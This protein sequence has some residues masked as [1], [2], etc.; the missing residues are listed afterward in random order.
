MKINSPRAWIDVVV[1][2]FAVALFV[3]VTSW[4]TASPSD[5][6]SQAVTTSGATNIKQATA[7]SFLSAFTSVLA[8][9]DD[10]QM[11]NYVAAAQKL[12]PDLKDQ[13]TA[14]ANDFDLSDETA[15]NDDHHVSRHR[16]RVKICCN[17]R[18]TLVLPPWKAR[19]YLHTHPE[20]ERGA[21]NYCTPTPH[22]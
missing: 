9:V 16:R 20:C 14:A 22:A 13:I 12:R 19:I 10:N 7:S 1:V 21:C 4:L 11:A 3:T 6:I 2:T 8:R 15:G 5:E 18:H 17:D